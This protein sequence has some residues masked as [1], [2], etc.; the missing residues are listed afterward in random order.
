MVVFVGWIFTKI[1]VVTVTLIISIKKCLCYGIF[2][3]LPKTLNIYTNY[4][5]YYTKVQWCIC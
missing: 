4:K 5:D 2:I 1:V 3:I